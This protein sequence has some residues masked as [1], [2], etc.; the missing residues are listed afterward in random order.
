MD[1]N[2]YVAVWG[3]PRME[4]WSVI[5]EDSNN[6]FLLVKNFTSSK[7]FNP[8]NGMKFKSSNISKFNYKKI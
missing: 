8:L 4:M 7:K 3:R 2:L 6:S 5:G 1:N